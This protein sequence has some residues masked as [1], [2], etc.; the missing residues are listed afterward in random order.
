MEKQK[1]KDEEE[2]QRIM[3]EEAAE[4]ERRD[5]E[6]RRI[7]KSLEEKLQ[8]E[9]RVKDEVRT[10]MKAEESSKEFFNVL[11]KQGKPNQSFGSFNIISIC[12]NVNATYLSTYIMITIMIHIGAS[13]H[14][15]NMQKKFVESYYS[16][17]EKNLV[18]CVESTKR[19]EEIKQE[20]IDEEAQKVPITHLLSHSSSS[21]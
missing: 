5:I 18:D 17:K 10:L 7:Q 13:E 16:N 19:Y 1:R 14:E 4:K 9:K 12:A 21:F 6:I 8:N 2:K 3:Q 11:I 15:I 20:V